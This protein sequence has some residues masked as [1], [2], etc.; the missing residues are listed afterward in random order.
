MWFS[1]E[2]ARKLLNAADV[3]YDIDEDDEQE[4]HLS[5][6]LNMN[7]TWAWAMAMGEDVP[8]DKLPEVAR[9]F[10]CY[11]HAGILYWVSEQNDGMRSEFHDN[12]RSI[13]FVKNE[14]AI[15][16]RIP[17]STKR[18]YEKVSYT[19]GAS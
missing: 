1:I 8:D 18:A 7:D 12:N 2:E 3:F 10:W 5:Q 9:L 19:L 11:G 6:T 15:L 13:D 4:G 14:E 16:K 17:D